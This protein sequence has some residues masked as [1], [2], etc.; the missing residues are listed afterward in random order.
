MALALDR[1]RV[2]AGLA[3]LSVPFAALAG[4]VHQGTYT[5][6]SVT[7]DIKNLRGIFV[8]GSVLLLSIGIWQL[9]GKS[10]TVAK[11]IALATGFSLAASAVVEFMDLPSSGFR[12]QSGFWFGTVAAI[13]TVASGF[14]LPRGA[15]TVP[16]P[17]A[18]TNAR[19]D[20]RHQVGVGLFTASSTALLAC[21]FL[22]WGTYKFGTS[23]GLVTV[24]GVHLFRL[25][26][27]SQASTSSTFGFGEIVGFYLTLVFS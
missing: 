7:Y 2:G 20:R 17:E 14:V 3:L 5:A 23:R 19:V 15:A 21:F 4:A 11:G 18:P 22:P 6:H 24:Y 27:E 16:N 13:L 9:F 12:I 10:D 1:R 8:I 25:P 26:F